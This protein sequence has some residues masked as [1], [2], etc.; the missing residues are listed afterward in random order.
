[1]SEA[2]SATTTLTFRC[3]S[4]RSGGDERSFFAWLHSFAIEVCGVHDSI[5]ITFRVDDDSLREVVAILARYDLPMR[6]LEALE[7]AGNR[8]WFRREGTYWYSRVFGDE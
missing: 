7:N 8:H 1:M 5:A 4:F 6:Q 2:V 3:P